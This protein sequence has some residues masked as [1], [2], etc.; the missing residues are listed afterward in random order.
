MK[1]LFQ[2]KFLKSEY[3]S[4]FD[5][6]DDLINY[7]ERSDQWLIKYIARFREIMIS[8]SAYPWNSK[9]LNTFTRYRDCQCPIYV[10]LRDWK[11]CRE[12]PYQDLICDLGASLVLLIEEQ[13]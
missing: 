3:N 7:V 1:S 8:D 9:D 13:L 10:G 11:R 2:K 4:E 12:F 5:A 6:C